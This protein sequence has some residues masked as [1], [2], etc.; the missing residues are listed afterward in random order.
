ME[1]ARESGELLSSDRFQGLSEIVQNA[2]DVEATQVRVMLRPND[3]LVCHDGN[4]VRLEHILGLATPWFSTK[5]DE[6]ATT[7]RFGVGLMTLRSLSRALEVHCYPYHVRLGDSALS[8]ADVPNMPPGFDEPGWTVLRLPLSQGAVTQAELEAWLNRWDHSALLFLRHV[9]RVALKEP[10]GR[11]VRE[12]T[13]SRHDY[14]EMTIVESSP[15]RS[16]KRQLVRADDRRSW[17]VYSEEALTPA[18]VTRVRK[19]TGKTTPVAV[20]LPLDEAGSGQIHAGLPVIHTRLPLFANAQFDPLTSRRDLAD[21]SWNESLVPLVADLWSQAALDL[22]SRDP[23]AAW[24]TMPAPEMIDGEID[25]PFIQ[26]LEDSIVGRAVSWV[27]SRI[28]FFIP[29]LGEINLSNLAVEARP[30]EGILN[31]SETAGLAELPATLPYEARDSSWTWRSVLDSW[32]GGGAD[33]PEPVSVEQALGLLGDETRPVPRTISLVAAAVEEGLG[34]R[35]LELPCVVAQDGRHIVPP[36]WDSPVALAAESSNLADQ[37]RVVTLIHPGHLENRTAPRT[38][39]DWLRKCGALVDTSD[40]RVVVRRIAA[41]GRAGRKMEEPLTDEQVQA[42]RSAFELLDPEEMRELG[43][44]VGKGILLE[45]YTYELRGQRRLRKSTSARPVEAYLSKGIDRDPDS[46]AVAA[47]GSPG[48]VW[49][50][51]RYARIIR[52]PAGRQG[53]GAQ[54]FLRLLGAE[55]APRL[56]PHP[57]LERRFASERLGLPKEFQGSS[58]ARSQELRSRG[59]SY[60]LMDR[61]CPDLMAVIQDISKLRSRNKRRKR[62]GALLGTLGRA[63]E[64]LYSDFSEVDS[65]QDS[66]AWREQGRI[67][68]AWLW[69]AGE[70]AWLD[71]EGGAPRRPRELRFRTPGTEAIYGKSSPDYLYGELYTPA[72]YG[73]LAVLGISG[74]PSRSELVDRL[75]K[76]RDGSESQGELTQ[77]QPMAEAGVVYKALARSISSGVSTSDMNASQIRTEFGRSPGLLLTDQGWLQPASVFGGLPFLGRYRPFAPLIDGA[78]SLWSVLNLREPSADDCIDVVREMARGRNAP[79]DSDEA[80]LMETLRALARQVAEARSQEQRRKLATLPLWT[81]IGWVWKRPIFATGDTVLAEGL[82]DSIPIWEPGG[83]LEQFRPLLGSLRVREINVGDAELVE[84]AEAFEDEESTD[85]FRLAVQQLQADLTR[86]DAELANGLRIEWERLLGF[87]VWVHPSL[88]LS[89]S[90]ERGGLSE[91]HQCDVTARFDLSKESVFVRSRADL[92]AA[93][94]GGRALAELFRGDSRH[95]AMVWRVACDRAEAGRK[96]RPL[97]LAGQWAERRRA[98]NEEEIRSRTEAFRDN[99]ASRHKGN[100]GPVPNSTGTGEHPAIPEN[101]GGNQ[102]PVLPVAPRVL[103]EPQSLKLTDPDGRINEGSEGGRDV[104]QR[105]KKLVEPSPKTKSPANRVSFRA[106]TEVDKETVGMELVK[107]LLGSGRDEIDEIIDLRT[108]RGVGADAFDELRRFFELK[109]SSGAEPDQVTLTNAEV[110]RALSTEDYFLVVVSGVEGADAHPSVRV[111]VDPLRQ[112]QLLDRGEITL[113]GVR[114]STSLIYDFSPVADSIESGEQD[115]P[116]D[117][118][119]ESWDPEGIVTFTG[120]TSV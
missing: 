88:A 106:Y 63:L 84:L 25:S 118:R 8:P 111:V 51:D 50:H 13:L 104:K 45:A 109:V 61:D 6:G 112:L 16:I 116:V 28:S 29:E 80:I 87:N 37:L 39:L 75:K 120:T 62:A 44:D 24:R 35:L 92:T 19:A 15:V 42:L 101:G 20:A 94:G 57:R 65:A 64:R 73:A 86:N 2:D 17:M 102:A 115:G 113:S 71:D 81:S 54:K 22:F 30:L 18:G 78:G 95:I 53:V 108:Q 9:S 52:S 34:Q 68:A 11:L 110:K 107:M 14:G 12:L 117:G 76:L 82:R 48:I 93:D 5:G 1:A 99:T 41:A 119:E 26:R 36:L 83:D 38:V 72:R 7:G 79:L 89:V 33:L 47:E 56:R 91:V 3:L 90:V 69:D 114:S 59:A 100:R 21:N 32:R 10:G 74:D 96:D 49:L 98:K 105:S 31:E 55:T 43:P 77:N 23:K 103:V 4:P 85:F 66:Y 46:F 27:A 97:E 70:V 58:P 60:T 40:D 67:P